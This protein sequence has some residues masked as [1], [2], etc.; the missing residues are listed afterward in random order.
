MK[1]DD[2]QFHNFRH[3]GEWGWKW[4]YTIC[5][6]LV[7]GH[8]DWT[9]MPQNR[10]E[11]LSDA[12]DENSGYK[13]RQRWYE[14]V[15]FV[16]TSSTAS[17]WGFPTLSQLSVYLAS[18]I[19]YMGL[20]GQIVTLL[21]VYGLGVTSVAYY[22]SQQE[23]LRLRLRC[24]QG[25]P[26]RLI[27]SATTF[28]MLAA[29]EAMGEKGVGITAKGM[30]DGFSYETLHSV[31]KHIMSAYSEI[32]HKELRNM[33]RTVFTAIS[34]DGIRVHLADFCEATSSNESFDM[35]SMISAFDT[36]RKKGFLERLFYDAAGVSSKKVDDES[37][38]SETSPKVTHG[39]DSAVAVA[40][41]SPTSLFN[42][43]D[44]SNSAK[45][46]DRSH[47]PNEEP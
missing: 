24:A 45:T 6:V 15:R 8:T 17:R 40:P 4:P 44:A 29:L 26:S 14:G 2:S 23:P 12:G 16:F 42:R 37:S 33:S 20:V 28:Y 10:Y 1:Y 25:L 18:T 13:M 31:F 39:G 32:D 27:Q 47:K 11:K 41:R 3:V 38:A 36:D 46:E 43:R 30:K 19:V 35:H 7:K 21:A 5:K 34:K 9:G 22:K